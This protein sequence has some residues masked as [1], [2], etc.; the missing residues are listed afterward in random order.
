MIETVRPLF[1]LS[2]SHKVFHR[3]HPGFCHVSIDREIIFG[4]KAFSVEPGLAVRNEK[5]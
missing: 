2:M 3:F 4:V 1:T 5:I